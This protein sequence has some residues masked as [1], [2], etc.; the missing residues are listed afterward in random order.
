[1]RVLYMEDDPI[2][3]E[4][5]AKWL[6]ASGHAVVGVANGTAAMAALERETFDMVI[7][8]WNVPGT[9]GQDLLNWMRSR[10]LETPVVFATAC[11][12]E[13]EAAAI[14]RLGADDYVVKPLRRLEFVARIEAIG[15]RAGVFGSPR[16]ATWSVGPYT[17]DAR[18]ESVLLDG[19]PMQLTP[20]L[21]KLAIYLFRRL[22]AVISRSHLYEELWHHKSSLDT[23]TLDTHMCRLR[24]LL[25]LD[26]RHGF[27]LVSV[28]QTGYRL[29]SCPAE[30]RAA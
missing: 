10:E 27:R 7:F 21:A 28:Y 29:E 26:G 6:S 24:Q 16:K 5:V 17:V 23:R 2:Q 14:F 1:M 8:D 30:M 9:S 15:R 20:R 22:D 19:V 18:H 12:G 11:N 25:Q 4:L 3:L 13:F